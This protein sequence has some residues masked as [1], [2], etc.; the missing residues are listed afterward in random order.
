MRGKLV[1]LIFLVAI[2]SATSTAEELRGDVNGDGKVT[3]VDALMALQMAV[4]KLPEDVRADVTGDGTVT[5]VDAFRIL[6]LAVGDQEELVSEMYGVISGIDVGKVVKDERMNWYITKDDG[7]VVAVSVVISGGTVKDF[8]RG[9]LPDPTMRVYTSEDVV[10]E[11]LK[12]RDPEVLKRDIGS[13]KIRLE[14][15][16]F[17]SKIKAGIASFLTRFT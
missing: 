4:G 5:A 13:G 3:S 1:S 15:V 11:L 14:G 17:A 16:G 8:R 7:S 2:L 6:Q 10:R 12:T 9:E